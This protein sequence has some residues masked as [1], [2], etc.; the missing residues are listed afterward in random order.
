MLGKRAIHFPRRESELAGFFNMVVDQLDAGVAE[1]YGISPEIM[2]ELRQYRDGIRQKIS[3]A[4]QLFGE[5]QAKT[6]EKNEMVREGSLAFRRVLK[7]IQDDK[8]FEEP[9][10]ELLGFRVLS[11]KP[12]LREVKPVIKKITVL[13]DKVLVKWLKG[14]MDGVIVYSRYDDTEFE[15]IAR[16][17]YSPFV[18][19]RKNRSKHPE[20]R[21]Y[22]MQYLKN[23]EQVGLESPVS[24]IIAEVL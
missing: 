21:H 8:N 7:R 18:D 9:D 2:E 10:A 19:L 15:E 6:E 16:V 24:R 3:E 12:D 11:E 4:A 5:A 1:K 22:Y 13:H 17:S 23:D 20:A 14:K